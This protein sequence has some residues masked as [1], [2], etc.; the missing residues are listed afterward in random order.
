MSSISSMRLF[1]GCREF[2]PLTEPVTISTVE[3]FFIL[4][5]RLSGLAGEQAA[6]QRVLMEPGEIAVALH[7]LVAGG[8]RV[9][10]V[11]GLRPEAAVEQIHHGEGQRFT[12][13][14]GG[15]DQHGPHAV[16]VQIGQNLKGG[17][18]VGAGGD[19]GV[20]EAQKL[21][22]EKRQLVVV[23]EAVL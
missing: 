9:R 12:R 23:G 18:V 16:E 15:V 22:Q 19:A 10:D 2:N 8:G 3:P 1:A 17:D 13:G 7:R 14:A 20:R 4:G 6:D 11:N 5:V 21:V